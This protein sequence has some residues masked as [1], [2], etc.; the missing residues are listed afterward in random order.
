M[1]QFRI[2]CRCHADGLGEDR[3]DTGA[4]HAVQTL[5]P[6]VI[7]R[8]LQPVDCRCRVYHLRDLFLERHAR[9]EVL[10]P[11]GDA[12][13]GVEIA[14]RLVRRR[15]GQLLLSFLDGRCPSAANSLWRP[16]TQAF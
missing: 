9:H 11:F 12:Q 1:Q 14:L 15:H 7:G 5:V 2:P 8:H 6:P 4:C 13:A 3:G 16:E 10:D